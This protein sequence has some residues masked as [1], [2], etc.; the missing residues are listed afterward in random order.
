MTPPN[1]G[2]SGGSC[3]PSIVVVALGEP[4]SPVTCSA[5]PPEDLNARATADIAIAPNCRI[6]FIRRVSHQTRV[7]HGAPPVSKPWPPNSVRRD[8]Q[9]LILVKL[10]MAAICAL[11]SVLVSA[12]GGSSPLRNVRPAPPVTF[13]APMLAEPRKASAMLRTASSSVAC[14]ANQRSA[15]STKIRVGP[16]GETLSTRGAAR[17]AE[18]G[19][20]IVFR[21]L[22]PQHHDAAAERIAGCYRRVDA[23]P[24]GGRLGLR[25]STATAGLDPDLVEAGDHLRNRV[26]RNG[27]V[28]LLATSSISNSRPLC[29][30][31]S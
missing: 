4:R 28:L 12:S 18:G 3:L 11:W 20:E 24:G 9:T 8:R 2:F 19:G 27:P 14:P 16:D 26:V 15:G 30:A 10:R 31:A 7:A 6:A 1:G 23:A 5:K 17:G 29:R 22:Q 25:S 21:R 13:D